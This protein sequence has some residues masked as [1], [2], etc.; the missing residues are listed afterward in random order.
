MAFDNNKSLHGTKVIQAVAIYP[1][2][3]K[4]STPEALAAGEVVSGGDYSDSYTGNVSVSGGDL[5]IFTAQSN[6][7]I[8]IG[9]E[10]AKCSVV[11]ATTVNI[12]ARAQLGTTAEAITSGRAI[13]VLHGGEADGSCRGYPKRPDGKGC[14]TDDSFDADVTREFL[15][16]DTQLVAGEIYYNGLRSISHSPT[17]LK[18]G[19]EIAKNASVTVTISDNTD[20]DVYSVPYPSVRN[21][22]ST[23]LRKLH[24][25]TGGYLRNRKMIVYSGF[26]FGNTFDPNECISREYIIDD[27]NISNDDV[28]TVRGVDPL[29]FTEEAKAKTHDVSA[30]VL[31]ADID[32]TSTQITLKNFAVGE[33]GADTESGTV[34]IDSELIDYTVNDSATG[35]L[36]I[37]NRG[38]GGSTQKDHKINA[39]VQKCLVLTDFNPITEIVNIL[40]TRTMIESRFYDDYTAVTA[41]VP[42][43]SGTVYVPKPESIKSFINTIIRSWA[44]NNISLY[45]DELA[46]KIRIKAVG[47]FEQQPV[48][49]TDTDIKRDSVRIDN[50]Y[51]DQITRASIGFAP[52]D[53]SKKV[54]DENSSILFQSIN[55]QTESVGT[56]EPQEDKTFYSKFLTS[57]DTD[58][59]IAV[60]GVS[61]I[62]NV[63]TKP[64][65]EYTFTLDYENYG[66]VSGGKIEEGEIINVK[67]ELSIDDDGQPMSQN[68]QILSIKD[69]MKNKQVQVKAVTYQDVINEQDF[70]FVI[71]ENKE[72]YVLSDEFAPTDAGEYTVF[73]A[74]NVTIGATSS[75]GF[76]FDTGAQ[77]NGVTLRVIHRGQILGAG[78]DGAAGPIARAPN[79]ND[80]PRRVV[81]SG[82]NGLNGG[83]AINI[84]VPTIIDAT[85]GVIYSGGGGAPSTDSIADSSVDPFFLSGGNG[86]SGGQGY[87]GGIGGS[88]G[89]A[90]VEG[91]TD[92]DA[93]IDGVSGSRSVAGSLAGLSAGAWGENSDSNLQSGEAGQAGYAIRSN[94]NSVTI[95]GDNDATIRGKRD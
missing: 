8:K 75:S 90:I 14:S 61:R 47:D 87:I 95:I 66:N 44:E 86:G 26:T 85:Q 27:F 11:N 45:F 15:I 77:N 3:C 49:I 36:D 69:D 2:A 65:Q 93:G 20:D 55:L 89:S 74:S 38:V 19:K 9:N 21:S 59:S 81:A 57:S 73:I 43:N 30:G 48:T 52:F 33:Y 76:A 7:Y 67:T 40:Q 5:T 60:G 46:K 83:D 13:R 10:L 68:L 84:T 62:A 63:N 42:N 34:L 24:A 80:N 4:Y 17:L 54:N 78:G 1:N 64:P 18:P 28:V 72:N 16:T 35:V 94:G 23:Y 25:R 6:E 39:S 32:N 88:G 56:L 70:D 37:V 91:E 22:R 53:A 50:K 29:I 71:N 41:T 82:L 51:Q 58:V 79:P 31:L 92:E 12:T